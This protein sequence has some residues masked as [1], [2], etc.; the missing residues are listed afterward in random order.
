MRLWIKSEF[1][2]ETWELNSRA[3]SDNE[4]LCVSGFS[5]HLTKHSRLRQLILVTIFVVEGNKGDRKTVLKPIPGFVHRDDVVYWLD[6]DESPKNRT[7]GKDIF[8]PKDTPIEEPKDGATQT[9]SDQE[10]SQA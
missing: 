10:P 6:Q 9:A 5:T 8:K 2:D 7:F 1:F 4:Y 3:R